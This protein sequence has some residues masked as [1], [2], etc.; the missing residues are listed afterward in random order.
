M[1]SKSTPAYDYT[2]DAHHAVGPFYFAI[3]CHTSSLQLYSKTDYL[4]NKTNVNPGVML[5]E[6]KKNFNDVA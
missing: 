3:V 6:E 4:E 2:A 1:R 5:F